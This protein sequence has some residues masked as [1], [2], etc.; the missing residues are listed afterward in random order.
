ML[1]SSDVELEDERVRQ[2]ELLAGERQTTSAEL[3]G[4]YAP[5][6]FGFHEA[7]HTAS[8]I[9]DLVD[10]RLLQ[11]PAIV[12]NPEC[13]RMAARASEALFNLYQTLGT[14]QIAAAHPD[15]GLRPEDLNASNDG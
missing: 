2:L 11:H 10:E 8:L 9:L 5:G 4:H 12:G 6:T 1:E 7:A 14:V 15:E 13:F 3:L